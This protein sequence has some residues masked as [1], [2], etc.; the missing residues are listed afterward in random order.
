MSHGRS[1]PGA[2]PHSLKCVGGYEAAPTGKSFD[3]S[4][5]SSNIAKLSLLYRDNSIV[6]NLSEAIY[7]LSKFLLK[8][9]PSGRRRPAPWARY[10]WPVVMASAPQPLRRLTT[11][12]FWWRLLIFLLVVGSTAE[13]LQANMRPEGMELDP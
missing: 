11:T 7:H 10:N 3:A 8:R 5:A 4:R 9:P 13:L 1:F 12:G 2:K 6:C